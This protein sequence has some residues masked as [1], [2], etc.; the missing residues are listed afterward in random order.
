MRLATLLVATILGLA[1]QL[2][3]P[4][5]QA[6]SISAQ[7]VQASCF[8]L[9]RQF[10]P[11]TQIEAEITPGLAVGL[12]EG[13]ASW[14]DQQSAAPGWTAFRQ[15]NLRAV[16]WK[17]AAEWTPADIES[18]RD[19]LTD[20]AKSS[21]EP[22]R[23]RTHRA[24]A[25]AIGR[26]HAAL[27]DALH[28]RYRFEVML[29]PIARGPQ[30][31]S[32]AQQLIALYDG[33]LAHENA[34]QLGSRYIERQRRLVSQ[35]AARKAHGLIKQLHD[36]L[37]ETG[38]D[39][40]ADVRA[41]DATLPQVRALI[42]QFAAAALLDRVERT[43][44]PVAEAA[45]T[46]AHSLQRAVEVDLVKAAQRAGLSAKP[47]YPRA[48]AV[49]D[50]SKGFNRS[51]YAEI[52]PQAAERARL[53]AEQLSLTYAREGHRQR[54]ETALRRS[55]LSTAKSWRVAASYPAN[56]KL[57]TPPYSASGVERLLC[58]L[59]MRGYEVR[60]SGTQLTLDARDARIER[61]VTKRLPRFEKLTVEIE[62]VS[63]RN[64]AIARGTRLRLDGGTPRELSAREWNAL[65][66]DL[67]RAQFAWW[68]EQG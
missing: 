30:T 20:C 62:E 23:A 21:Q 54:C 46:L 36:R 22:Q 27:N 19:T 65:L 12:A 39:R 40:L 60:L 6:Q 55:N 33:P 15:S 59:A 2:A 13:F 67:L 17:P 56:R 18:Y 48:D 26:Y 47:G 61:E 11:A 64:G 35:L 52:A 25:E 49:Y 1:P 16:R 32:G 7:Q 41:I 37:S 42:D 50:V 44:A 8:Y 68:A 10:A 14:D 38:S 4:P 63:T 51:P 34:T 66:P 53:A 31:L 9:W 29:T 57:P 3:A 28:A 58:E 45:D 43:W 24:A 5:A